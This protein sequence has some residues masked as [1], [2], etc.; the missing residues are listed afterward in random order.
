MQQSH[1]APL[2]IA[3][4]VVI[5]VGTAV[6][7]RPEGGIALGRIAALIESIRALRSQQRQVLL[8]TSGAVG[9]GAARLGFA[10]RPT[11]LADRQACAAAGQGA[12][13]SLYSDFLEQVGLTAAQVL[14]TQEDFQLPARYQNLTATLERLLSLGAVPVINENDTVASEEI[15]LV[16]GKVFGDN[17]RLSALVAAGLQADA[18]TLLSDVDAVYTAHPSEPE[19]SRIAVWADD[20]VRFGRLSAGGRGGMPAKIDA[21]RFAADGGVHAVIASGYHADTLTQIFAGEDVG[22]WFPAAG[23]PREAA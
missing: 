10:T 20:P 1:R 5:K 18:L 2:A 19:S 11:A 7:T 12:L 3:R 22:T 4:R 21:A 15:A 13:M 8:V 17:D 9:L 16:D 23:P 14:L 6:V